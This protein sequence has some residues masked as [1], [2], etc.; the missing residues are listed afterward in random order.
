MVY[1]EAKSKLVSKGS[2]PVLMEAVNARI[3]FK[4]RKPKFI[5]VL[6][7]SGKRTNKK[8]TLNGNSLDLNGGTEKAIYYEIIF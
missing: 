1:D 3:Q 7:H 5:Y 8:I 4:G 2:A 6:D